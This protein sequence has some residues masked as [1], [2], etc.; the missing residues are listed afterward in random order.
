MVSSK[1]LFRKNPY[2]WTQKVS[3]NNI[4]EHTYVF[5]KLF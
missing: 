1:Y 2:L 4:S 3:K 5:I